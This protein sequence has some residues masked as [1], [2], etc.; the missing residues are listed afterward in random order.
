MDKQAIKR[1]RDGRID[2][3]PS[4]QWSIRSEGSEI[5]PHVAIAASLP[6]SYGDEEET[7]VEYKRGGMRRF[8]LRQTIVQFRAAR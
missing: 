3:L 5:D 8:D 2:V 1:T 4:R 6:R 7:Q